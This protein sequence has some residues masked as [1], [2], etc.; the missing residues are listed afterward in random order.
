MYKDSTKSEAP[1]PI[2][3]NHVCEHLGWLFRDATLGMKNNTKGNDLFDFQVEFAYFLDNITRGPTYIVPK[4]I[5]ECN[6]FIEKIKASTT[7]N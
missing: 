1:K 5:A 3:V 4:L 6:Q 2:D 7:T